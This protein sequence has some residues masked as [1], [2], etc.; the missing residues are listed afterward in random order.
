MALARSVWPVI[1][2]LVFACKSA[3]GSE[4]SSAASLESAVAEKPAATAPA[5]AAPA[6]A[7]QPESAAI[8]KPAPDFTLPDLDGN[9]VQL[10]SFRGKTVVLE[11]F[12]P[13]CPFVQASHTKGSL[14][15]TGDRYTKEGVVWLAINS[16][17]KGKQGAGRENSLAGKQRFGFS[18]PVLLDES[19][20]VGKLYG[21]ERTPHMYVID[22]NGVLVYRGAID[23]SPDGEGESPTS[24]TLVRY[25]EEAIAAVKEQRPVTTPETKAYGCTVKYE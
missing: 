10:S 9:T 1:A 2:L 12:N 14:K 6:P 25:V 11:W 18:Y 20:A 4:P 17:A 22:P 24:G 15:G 16:G 3:G 7:A 19:G 21:A 5:P 23:N 8:G 13:G